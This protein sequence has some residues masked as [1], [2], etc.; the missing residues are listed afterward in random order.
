PV[1]SRVAT[2]GPRFAAVS[3]L[4]ARTSPKPGSSGLQNE[5][6]AAVRGSVTRSHSGSTATPP[7]SDGPGRMLPY[8][9]HQLRAVASSPGRSPVNPAVSGAPLSRWGWQ[10]PQPDGNP[11]Y[12]LSCPTASIC[13]AAGM[14]SS[15][16]HSTNSGST[17][18]G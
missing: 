4:S 2:P 1:A 16:F 13:F 15:I 9:Q 18:T 12:A 6:S 10:N 17:W 14:D 11:L 3:P 8:S 5:G 7:A